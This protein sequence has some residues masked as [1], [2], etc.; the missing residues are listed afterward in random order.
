MNRCDTLGYGRKLKNDLNFFMDIS[1]SG[2]NNF[3][4][5]YCNFKGAVIFRVTF[6][7]FNEFS[8]LSKVFFERIS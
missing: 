1:V 2:T 6:I 3:I 4:L 7:V 8:C 5:F